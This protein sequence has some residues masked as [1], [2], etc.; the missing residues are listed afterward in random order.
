MGIEACESRLGSEP[1]LGA[2]RGQPGTQGRPGSPWQRAAAPRSLPPPPPFG[3]LMA[4]VPRSDGLQ[5]ASTGPAGVPLQGRGNNRGRA[6][7]FQVWGRRREASH[8]LAW[9]PDAEG[10]RGTAMR[11][12]TPGEPSVR[13]L[14]VSG[15]LGQSCCLGAREAGRQGRGSRPRQDAGTR[16]WPSVGAATRSDASASPGGARLRCK[17]S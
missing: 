9:V 15:A 7:T 14:A 1:G 11:R 3:G 6:M 17:R 16:H 4:K 12:R 5:G 8:D 10:G 2:G 13:V